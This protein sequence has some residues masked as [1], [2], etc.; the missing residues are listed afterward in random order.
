MKY[1]VSLQSIAWLNGRRNDN[2]LEISPKFSA[3]PFGW[4]QNEAL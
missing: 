1:D 3:D 2:S 4:S